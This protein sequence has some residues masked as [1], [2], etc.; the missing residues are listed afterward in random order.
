VKTLESL[1][2]G[3]RFISTDEIPSMLAM[4]GGLTTRKNSES[5]WLFRRGNPRILSHAVRE[6]I[7]APRREHSRKPIEAYQRI[8]EFCPG[9]RLEL[10]ART[11]WPEWAAYGNQIGMF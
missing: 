9:P 4:G 7:V 1:A 5:C 6:M 8:E 3:P 2:K 10:F 11:A